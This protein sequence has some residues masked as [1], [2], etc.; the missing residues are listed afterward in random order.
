MQSIFS[1]QPMRLA[2][3]LAGG[4]ALFEGFSTS[5]TMF[6]MLGILLVAQAIFNLTCMGGA[7]RAPRNRR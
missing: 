1:I 3:F 7:C 5:E 4:Y 6:F 2:Y